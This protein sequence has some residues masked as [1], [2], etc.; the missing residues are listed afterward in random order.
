MGLDDP[1]LKM[2][3]SLAGLR[4]GHAI[5]LLDSPKTI[6]RS[7]MRAVTDSGTALDP[8]HISP[9]VDNLLV[10]FE[11]LTGHSRE[12]TLAKFTGQGYGVLK[13]EV[14]EAAIEKVSE[15]QAIY[16]SIR[17]DD[18]VLD[19]ILATGAEQAEHVA[20]ATLDAA[21]RVTGLR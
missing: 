17:D 3:K 15:I 16:Q 10:L 18:T 1:A 20:D 4:D 2:S 21:M 6:Q 11:T 9:G 7:V 5:G 12:A 14:A 8:D 13:R 19:R